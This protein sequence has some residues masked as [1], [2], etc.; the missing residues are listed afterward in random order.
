[1]VLSNLN[2]SSV[3]DISK[4]WNLLMTSRAKYRAL[5][6]QAFRLMLNF[7]WLVLLKLVSGL[8]KAALRTLDDL[9]MG[10]EI[11]R[12]WR[13]SKE[14]YCNKAVRSSVL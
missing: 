3:I 7:P 9:E 1:M 12:I 2:A 14:L 6:F 13:S 4:K 5:M 8:P 10:L 11:Y